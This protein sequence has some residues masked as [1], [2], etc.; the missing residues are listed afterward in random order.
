[1]AK[2]HYWSEKDEEEFKKLW[3]EKSPYHL[4]IYF[5]TNVDIINEKALELNLP[6]YKSNRWTKEEEDLLK[7]YAKKYVTKTIAKKLGRSYLAVQ[8]KA[9]KL[10]IELHSEVDPWKKWMIDYLKENINKKPIGEIE[11]ILGISY[12]RILTKCNELGIE[13]ISEK[14]TEEEINILKKYASLCHYT[15]LVNVLPRR[16]VGAI[17]A[18]AFELGIETISNYHKLDENIS[19]YIKENWG[20]MSVSDIARELQ[21]SLGVVYRYK[22]ELNLP[23]VNQ[24]V[25]WTEEKIDK[26]RKLAKKYNR[27]EI[28][29]KL[30]TSEQQVSKYANLH[31]IELQ[32]AK[33]FWTKKLDEELL[34]L[35]QEKV[36]ISEISDLMQIKA[37]A[38]RSR[39]KQIG[40]LEHVKRE[41][42][43]WT[44]E[45]LQQL[46]LLYKIYDIK[47][48]SAILRIKVPTIRSKMKRLGLKPYSK[49]WT[50]SDD[51][52]L[53]ELVCIYDIVDICYKM[54]KS[55][56]CIKQ[57]AEAL[58]LNL[59]EVKRKKWTL[60]EENR[61]KKLIKNTS[62]RE[63]SVIFH[64]T[65]SSIT[66]K[67]KY[68]GLPLPTNTYF[69]TEEEITKLKLWAET[70]S[71]EEIS[72]E[73][74]KSYQ[75]VSLKASKLGIGLNKNIKYWT[76]EEENF[77]KENIDKMSTFLIAKE[78]D[79]T[80]NAVCERAK[81][82]GLSVDFDH[83]RW[84]D[85]EKEYLEDNWGYVSKETI[86]K[87][88][89][90]S[91]SAI[92]N[93]AYELNLGSYASNNYNGMTIQEIA[94]IFMISRQTI[95]TNWVS[96]GLKIS[97]QKISEF[98]SFSYVTIK[99]LYEF[100]YLNQNIWDSRYLEK[101]IL[102]E[103]PEWLLK[104]RESDI[105][106]KTTE[107]LI[108][109]RQ[110]LKLSEKFFYQLQESEEESLG[111]T[112]A[113]EEH[114]KIKKID[115]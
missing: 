83:R 15:E 9:L 55:E 33:V 6:P 48:L 50:I 34:E 2:K 96:L 95:M 85:E 91:L 98:D 59:L 104:K 36:P 46:K 54:E 73:L 52:K 51:L 84:S 81:K 10:G 8:K 71:I 16:S 74:G 115:G 94:D 13:Y 32:D 44:E 64:R 22:K 105:V 58:G 40:T 14:W 45:K 3:S 42:S 111:S 106:S 113:E 31:N 41:N 76:E 21:V 53:K 66:A 26:L 18:K 67:L 29:K 49:E 108:L 101:N 35:Y 20:K 37:N 72:D 90:R 57:H 39:L 1:M 60:E 11:G 114:M 62:L 69:W 80:E 12:R 89:E 86:A 70:K 24:K 17:S 27:K 77:I 43:V 93:K 103:E 19:K 30:H 107:K 4:S 78:L 7:E 68:M 5:H 63:L 110:Q 82:L 97:K 47:E 100:L 102:G 56:A 25:I 79:R 88:L 61:L 28:A 38:I 65:E 87:K 92:Q 112:L 23:N 99:D 109:T 75:S